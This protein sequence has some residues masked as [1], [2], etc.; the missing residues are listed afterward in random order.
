MRPYTTKKKKK[1][2]KHEV[3]AHACNPSHLGGGEL[4]DHGLKPAQ[5]K[6]SET[7]SQPI[8]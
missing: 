1:K 3:V 7:P 8:N 4:K 6:V 2:K 5:A